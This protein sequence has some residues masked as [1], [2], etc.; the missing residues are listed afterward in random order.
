M[1]QFC[2]PLRY[3]GGKGRL[4]RYLGEVMRMNGLAGGTYV[5]PFAGGAGIAIGLLMN[6]TAS[7]IVL[8]DADPA[9]YRFWKSVR[10]YNDEFV[11]AI[12]SA[13]LTV[14]EWERQHRIY[15]DRFNRSEFETGFSAFYLNRTNR[16][17][18]L[19]GG[20]IGGKSQN[21]NFKI[22][23]RFNRDEL[24]ERVRAI[25]DKADRI[26]LYCSDAAYFLRS[27][28]PGE[29]DPSDTLV[30]AD[31]PYY[32]KGS[33]LY[34]NHCSREDHIELAS[35]MQDLKYKW[36]LSYDDVPEIQQIYGWA[37]P[38]EFYMYHSANIMHVG[39]ELFYSGKDTAMPEG[40]VVPSRAESD[41]GEAV[42]SV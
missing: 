4:T 15:M 42:L 25:G 13:E 29:C 22:G 9:I 26:S 17:G 3:P 28:L 6:G 23:A 21:G 31:P 5:E 40:E 8:N 24:A 11:E 35:V 33:S 12:L 38:V 19:S 41:V 27:Y 20:P 30:Y 34:L 2:T 37:K 36:V 14:D 18:I 10:D 39:K 1:M 32:E 7:R 16:S